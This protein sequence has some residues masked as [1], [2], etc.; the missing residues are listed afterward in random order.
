MHDSWRG[1]RS[2]ALIA[3][4][5]VALLWSGASRGGTLVET[6]LFAGNTEQAIQTAALAAEAAPQDLDAQ[7]LYIDL[8]LSSGL[9]SMAERAYNER[10]SV[11]PTNPDVHY[12]VGRAARS[13]AAAAK[14]YE[15]ALRLNPD[16][17][18][19]H[20]G[21]AAVH[22]AAGAHPDAAHA[23]FRAINLDPNL[24]E[25]WLGL[26]RADL[27][28]G[29]GA[30]AL[31]LAK[32]GIKYV[33]QEPGLY[34]V[35]AEMVPA[36]A[37][38]VLSG[39][40]DRGVDDPRVSAALAASLLIEGD[41]DAALVTARHALATDR[42]DVE[43]TRVALFAAAIT[44]GTLDNAGYQRLIEARDVQES[45]PVAALARF[46]KLV[47][48]YPGCAL[49]WLGRSQVKRQLKDTE[50]AVEDSGKAANLAPGNIEVEASHGLLLLDMGLFVDAARFLRVASEGRPWDASLGLGFAAALTGS[51][52]PEDA[53]RVLAVLNDLHPYDARTTIQYGQAL[54]D[55]GQ[56]EEAYQLVRGALKRVPDP[57][58][59]VAM[60]M[61]ATAAK[62]YAEAADILEQLAAQ[63]GRETL[64]QEARRLRELEAAGG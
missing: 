4:M 45:D 11:D 29:L 8:L 28:M 21:M 60:V 63:T 51:H 42:T 14:A 43:A 10:V 27:A 57:R 61:T 5:G 7:E 48:D 56:A 26:I 62:H 41:A 20:M 23:Y 47:S 13:G 19:S 40:V 39:A 35:V 53:A 50:G 25:A 24:A 17:A 44:S 34:L 6:Q 54:V 64:A 58:L 32:K 12:L 9:G 3:L 33:P 52:K 1:G 38:R 37:I 59:A 16:H 31:E 46:D 18:R 2:V 36:D 30:E 22:M 49:T 55:S 15:K